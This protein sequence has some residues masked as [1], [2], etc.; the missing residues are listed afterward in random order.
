MGGPDPVPGVRLAHV[1]VLNQPWGLDCISRGSTLS[2]GVYHF[3]WTRGGSGPA[4][5]VGSG[6]VV[7]SE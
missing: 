2:L 6:A 7:D 5:V 4:H 3:L 1:E